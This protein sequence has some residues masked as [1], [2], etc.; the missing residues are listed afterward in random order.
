M[1]PFKKSVL[2]V[3]TIILVIFLIIIAIMLYN[4]KNNMVY[5]P[6]VADCPDYWVDMSNGDASNCRN[7]K[8]L[9]N[10]NCRTEMNFSND[11]WKGSN[12]LC[13]KYKWA[14]TCNLTWDGVTNNNN[15][16]V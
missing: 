16:C 4:S 7:I 8:K 9:G 13:A 10:S 15:A 14:K 12:G 11:L 5:P 6:V 3:A 2:M 1:D